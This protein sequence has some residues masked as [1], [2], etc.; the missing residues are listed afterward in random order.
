MD[1]K[2]F[3]GEIFCLK[4]FIFWELVYIRNPREA[5]IPCYQIYHKTPLR[6]PSGSQDTV[7]LGR[8]PKRLESEF[9]FIFRFLG[10]YYKT[11]GTLTAF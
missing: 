5:G 8:S 7:V 2:V 3:F 11:P 9:R 4:H 1:S 6:P 10:T